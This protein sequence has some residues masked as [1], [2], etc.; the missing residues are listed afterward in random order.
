MFSFFRSVAFGSQSSPSD[1]EIG[2]LENLILGILYGAGGEIKGKTRLQKII[3]ILREDF[4]IRKIPKFSKD[5]F[6]PYS[7]A[8]EDALQNLIN[9]NWVKTE[10][11]E[12]PI[13]QETDSGYRI[14][15]ILNK[16]SSEA[17]DIGKNSFEKLSEPVRD[18]IRRLAEMNMYTL[19]SYVYTFHKD[20]T[21]KSIIKELF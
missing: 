16:D 12:T 14:D 10:M 18:S 13:F 19:I 3:F 4:L 7:K 21:E 6:G 20:Y 15:I 1:K 11:V 5:K 8:V 17:L 2:Y 9:K